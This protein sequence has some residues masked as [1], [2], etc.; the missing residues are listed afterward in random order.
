MSE[1][2]SIVSVEIVANTVT[3]TQPGFGTAL[4]LT[5]HTRFTDQYRV[6]TETAD[7]LADGFSTQDRAYKQLRALFSQ[8]PRPE[9]AIVGRLPAAPSFAYTVTVT[10]AVEGQHVKVSVLDTAG[11][12]NDIDYTIPAAA[13]TATVATAV[14]A[15]IDAL[16]GVAASAVA[17]VITVT[18]E[19]PG[20]R[21]DCSRSLNCTI[22]ETTADA[23]YDTELSA[24]Q[25][26][27]DDWYF[28]LT[29]SDSDA[30]VTAVAAWVLDKT[31]LYA[32]QT[33]DARE[34]LGT[35]VTGAALAAA[36]N[37]RTFGIYQYD[38]SEMSAAAW[39]GYGAAQTPG[40][41]TWCHKQLTGVTATP[42]T[43][44]QKLNL[45]TNDLNHYM[46]VAG[47]S[48]TRQG[49]VASGEYIDII[50]G[51]DALEADLQASVDAV[52]ISNGK[53][54][55]TAHGLDLI[56]NAVLGSLKRFEGDQ[57]LL[58]TGSSIV[59]MPELSAIPAIDKSNRI[60]R[61]VKFQAVLQGAIH[62]VEIRG[63][64]TL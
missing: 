60:L 8:S 45:E 55:Y 41:V 12:R 62:K 50:H 11:T 57:A 42:L 13:T 36:N 58:V 22:T 44:T 25:L 21:P 59:I 33:N 56:A 43:T 23:D 18:P 38:P 35:S 37:N 9:Q 51:L 10:S 17:A 30:N 14:A 7:M 27:N 47:V 20:F 52:L 54:P 6:Y 16:T 19:T 64:V 29:D 26:V 48:R 61:N 39:V 46:T 15:L 24:L 63:T 34:I 2:D 4:S 49:T 1:I 53:V 5:Y 32:Y 40:F 28:V 3:P 31:K